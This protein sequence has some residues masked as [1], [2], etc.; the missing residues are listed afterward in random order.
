MPATLE[1]LI[2]QIEAVA[3]HSST[4]PVAP[5]GGD[6]H[7]FFRHPFVPQEPYE[8]GKLWD[9]VYAYL[10]LRLAADIL[11]QTFHRG[12]YG[13]DGLFR[14]WVAGVRTLRGWDSTC[15]SC[16][17]VKLWGVMTFLLGRME[18]GA[19]QTPPAIDSQLDHQSSTSLQPSESSSTPVLGKRPA[20]PDVEVPQVVKKSKL[21]SSTGPC[22]VA[23]S[24]ETGVQEPSAP[25]PSGSVSDQQDQVALVKIPR[26][27]GLW[28]VNE[29]S[30]LHNV[31]LDSIRARKLLPQDV[32]Q[33]YR[34]MINLLRRRQQ[35][36]S[37]PPTPPI[38][39]VLE[40]FG[41]RNKLSV[42]DWLSRNPSESLQQLDIFC[43]LRLTL[44]PSTLLPSDS[45]LLRS[46]GEAPWHRHDVFNLGLPEFQLPSLPDD[47]TQTTYVSDMLGLFYNPSQKRIN[48]GVRTIVAGVTF[49]RMDTSELPLNY[50]FPEVEHPNKNVSQSL[51]AAHH[52]KH[53]HETKKQ[54]QYV[55]ECLEVMSNMVNR[56]YTLLEAVASLR[57][58]YHH[59]VHLSRSPLNN[60]EQLLAEYEDMTRKLGTGTLSSG[61]FGPLV[62]FLVSGVKGLMIYPNDKQRFGA[63]K[64]SHF[65]VLVDKINGTKSIEEPI[66]KYTQQYILETIE[67]V[68]FAAKGFDPSNLNDV[69]WQECQF[70]KMQLAKALE[71]DLYNFCTHRATFSGGEI[72]NAPLFDL[73]DI[74]AGKDNSKKKKSL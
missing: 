5:P 67:H 9:Q 74:P 12:S 72:Y 46:A 21:S 38:Q 14:E 19:Q 1:D 8:D 57:A 3:P 43:H 62:A 66:W 40:P 35:G 16:L 6:F 44:F 47:D 30:C 25:V 60:Q 53:L 4:I 63:L 69:G 37:L 45:L 24:G 58:K 10:E 36:I 20:D 17:E 70:S 18:A 26:P 55:S 31:T 22:D 52:F 64:L 56:I 7:E 49:A 34:S 48:Q 61:V 68:F 32:P 71:V 27:T 15:D 13:F 29:S 54:T 23:S 50:I 11:P 73:P 28:V 33:V 2:S 42:R 39:D 65:V 59:S 41:I 51:E